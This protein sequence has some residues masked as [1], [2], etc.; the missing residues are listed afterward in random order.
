ML[1]S[2]TC[3]CG[4]TTT[5]SIRASPPRISTITWDDPWC[6]YSCTGT[7]STS[8]YDAFTSKGGLLVGFR[9]G[10]SWAHFGEAKVEGAS[11]A[12]GHLTGYY[13]PISLGLGYTSESGRIALPYNATTLEADVGYSGF[14]VEPAVGLALGPLYAA[15]TLAVI[16][17]E[18]AIT[19][20][21]NSHT[22]EAS[23]TGYRPGGRVAL[24]LYT[25]GPI[26]FKLVADFRYLITPEAMIVSGGGASP[27]SY[28]GWS[29]AFGLMATM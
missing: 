22:D 14:F 10:W 23:G 11:S 17:G 2:S 27:E 20:D 13:G 15:L 19:L 25:K 7:R 26:T 8:Y 24:G 29:S 1:G 16:S 3:T 5:S 21:G 9:R 28:G 4:G 6:R 12:D 18:T